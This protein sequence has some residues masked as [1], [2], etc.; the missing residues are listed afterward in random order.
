MLMNTA[1]GAG[2]VFKYT[3][4]RFQFVRQLETSDYR[5]TGDIQFQ[6][7]YYRVRA[8][9]ENKETFDNRVLISGVQCRG[10]YLVSR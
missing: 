8:G 1:T 9:M 5:G 4:I 7:E 10:N 3:I 2:L 6:S